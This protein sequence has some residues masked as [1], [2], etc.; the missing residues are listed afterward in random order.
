MKKSFVIALLC[1]AVFAHAGF[2]KE[3]ME[4]KEQ[5]DH[6]KLV[7]V[8]DQA[9]KEGKASGCY[10]LGVVYEQ[11]TGNA[12]CAPA[13]PALSSVQRPAAARWRGGR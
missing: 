5:G 10:N 9:C 3:G 2:I 6:Q 7:E 12:D 1:G 4:A 13:A 8:Y 11:G